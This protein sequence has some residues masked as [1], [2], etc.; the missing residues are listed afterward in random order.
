MTNLWQKAVCF[1]AVENGTV[2]AFCGAVPLSDGEWEL[3]KMGSNPD[4]PHRGAGQAVFTACMNWALEH[5]A[6]RLLIYSNRKL[7]PALHIYAK[8][9]FR[10]IAVTGAPYSRA[11]IALEFIPA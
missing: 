10:E 11:D 2:L 9:G 7:K 3:E 8:C 1:F 4:V 6:R 5:G